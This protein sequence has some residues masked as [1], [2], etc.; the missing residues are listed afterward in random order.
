MNDQTP[1]DSSSS[2]AASDPSS[3]PALPDAANLPAPPNAVM[4]S[5]AP[6]DS[7]R[8]LK[9]NSYLRCAVNLLAL[10]I[11]AL[12]AIAIVMLL[13]YRPIFDRLFPAEILLAY[14]GFAAVVFQCVIDLHDWKGSVVKNF[15][16]VSYRFVALLLAF[17][18]L[19]HRRIIVLP[20]DWLGP[21]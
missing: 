17:F 19:I 13:L 9:F 18:V 7:A 14:L 2:R 20:G 4:Q 12:L 3:D 10:L 16:S 8:I 6:V 1:S 5:T 15:A 21:F 11:L